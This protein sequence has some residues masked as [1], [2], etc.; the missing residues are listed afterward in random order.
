MDTILFDLDGT[1]LPMDQ[2]AFMDV[3]LKELGQKCSAL[4]FEEKPA[5]KALWAGTKAM[6]EN[7]G[8]KT[9]E[10]VFWDV[11][12]SLLG[13]KAAQL[14]PAF[15]AFYAQEFDRTKIATSPNPL[16]AN[17]IKQLKEKG[18]TL[19]LASNPVFPKEAYR[20][21]LAWL[22]LVPEDFEMLTSYED[23][24]HCKPN[25]NYYR[26][27]LQKIGK[28][29]QRCLMV[30]NDLADDGPAKTLGMGFYLV[31]N[32]LLNANANDCD[33]HENGNFEALYKHL[34]MLPEIR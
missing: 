25:P 28:T 1:L 9:N 18:Y 2:N 33:N 34:L 26:E 22:G 23:F 6:I 4:G 7:S 14:K 24:C 13:K 15:Q 8:E 20:T 29:P 30:G 19:I 5:I 11:F 32:C 12:T 3:Y 16:A 27:I 21:R 17:L 31:T 10:D